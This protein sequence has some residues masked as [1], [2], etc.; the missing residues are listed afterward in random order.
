[1]FFSGFTSPFLAVLNP[2]AVQ[3][4]TYEDRP[5]AVCALDK[6]VALDARDLSKEK[7]S[8]WRVWVPKT[9]YLAQALIRMSYSLRG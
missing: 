8:G 9:S 3:S 4:G 6:R 2:I 7:W 1:M 5:V